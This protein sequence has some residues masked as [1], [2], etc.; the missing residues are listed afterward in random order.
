MFMFIH[1]FRHQNREINEMCP[2]TLCKKEIKYKTHIRC[3]YK[4]VQS[5]GLGMQ[6]EIRF[7]TFF[8]DFIF[9]L[10][11][12]YVCFNNSVPHHS[13][14]VWNSRV[15]GKEFIICHRVFDWMFHWISVL[16]PHSQFSCFDVFCVSTCAL[17]ASP[18]IKYNSLIIV[19]CLGLGFHQHIVHTMCVWNWTM[20]PNGRFKLIRIWIQ[21]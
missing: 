7:D 13:W 3:T 17:W 16:H 15:E 6:S 20:K 18:I 14:S 12:C 21:F 10:V 8:L 11:R 5:M 1:T 4:I 2:C 9:F 19:Q